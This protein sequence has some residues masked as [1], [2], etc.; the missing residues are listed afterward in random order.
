MVLLSQCRPRR[1]SRWFGA[2]SAVALVVAIGACGGSSPTAIQPA[3]SVASRSVAPSAASGAPA[4]PGATG[5]GSQRVLA[6]CSAGNLR[7]RIANWE[8]AA[9]SR[10]VAVYLN[11]RAGPGC[12][13]RGTPGVQLID[14]RGV[15]FVDSANLTGSRGPRI[16][17]GDPPV[18]VA[19]GA[20]IELDVQ[21]ANWCAAPPRFPLSVGAELA[22]KSGTVRSAPTPASLAEDAPPCTGRRQPTILRATHAWLGPTP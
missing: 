17:T 6:P 4:P 21:W 13:L 9:G 14:A 18:L 1:P 7:A 20:E 10:L 22:N 19:P 11:L 12:L 16:A 3:S 5:S 2:I 15:V 8:S